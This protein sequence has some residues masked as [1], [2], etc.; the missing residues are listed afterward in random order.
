VLRTY[1]LGESDRIIHLVTER[2]G[3]VRA[4]AKGVRKTK[5][6]FGS[7]LEPLSHV[8]LKL[9]E[10]RN[11]DTITEAETVDHFRAIRE[12]LDRFGRAMSL[13]EAVD[14]VVQEG[15]DDQRL[16]QMLVGA[17]RTL[18]AQPAPLVVAA[19]FWKLLAHVGFRPLLD[20]CA[21]CGEDNPIVAF[22]LDEGGVLCRSCAKG[23]RIT[24]E[25]VD[26]LR[27]ILGGDL[28]TVLAE[29]ASQA[30]YEVEHLATRAV[31]HHLERRMK[32][33]GLLH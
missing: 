9:Y 30:G 22:D 28:V 10:G 23:D 5:S 18:E 17:L 21:G 25:A 20:V 7:R 33:V 3:K 12:D 6:K 27:R 24:P 16:Y 26:L 1:K 11:L 32:S 13:L 4:V 29:P 8:A 14:G 19:F 2:R 15:E 31:E